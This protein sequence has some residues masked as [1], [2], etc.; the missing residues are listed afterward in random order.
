MPS[1]IL[2]PRTPREL[3]QRFREEQTDVERLEGRS[4]SAFF[5]N[6]IGK[7]DEKLTQERQE[8]YAA[9]VKYDAAVGELAG[10][11]ED[12]AR[13]QAELDSLRDCEDRYAAVLREKTQAVKAAGGDAA[14]KIL[15]LEEREADLES[16]GRELDEA[17]AAGEAAGPLR[18][19]S[20]T[21]CAARK[22]G[23]TGILWAAA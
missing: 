22:N 8:A 2:I 10:I 21:A 11:E 1:G 20:P 16:Q 12:L 18:T 9:R 23:E 7:K 6:V 13:C 3:E 17:L 19:G 14:E 15:K 4:L 5:Y